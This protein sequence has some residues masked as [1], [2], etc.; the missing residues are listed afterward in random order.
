MICQDLKIMMSQ[1][2]VQTTRD[3]DDIVE[4]SDLGHCMIPD[5]LGVGRKVRSGHFANCNS[6]EF[7][8]LNWKN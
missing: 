6:D 5:N 2:S 3:G 1:A 8:L 4:W 7:D